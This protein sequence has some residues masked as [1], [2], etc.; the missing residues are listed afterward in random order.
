MELIIDDKFYFSNLVFTE[1]SVSTL[2]SLTKAALIAKE[3]T[4]VAQNAAQVLI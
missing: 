2:E 4:Q 1:S 3:T